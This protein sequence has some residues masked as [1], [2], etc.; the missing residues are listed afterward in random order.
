MSKPPA[1]T[2]AVSTPLTV[3]MTLPPVILAL[4]TVPAARS[5]A[6]VQVRVPSPPPAAAKVPAPIAV[7]PGVGVQV[8]SVMKIWVPLPTG[9]SRT[10]W[11]LSSVAGASAF[12][13][14]L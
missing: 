5:A 4:T 8:R 10:K 7:L 1:L 2:G 3:K 9:S 14:V 11:S 12:W 13:P 6:A